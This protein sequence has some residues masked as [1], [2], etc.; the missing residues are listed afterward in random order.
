MLSYAH[1]VVLHFSGCSVAKT[2]VAG[3]I[4]GFGSIFFFCVHMLR[5][6]LAAQQLED[7][8]DTGNRSL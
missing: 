1:F 6:D 4:L 8:I 7:Y 5:D 2:T 3:A